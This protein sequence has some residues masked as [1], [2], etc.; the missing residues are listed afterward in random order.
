[1]SE[2]RNRRCKLTLA[3]EQVVADKYAAGVWTA[4]IGREFGISKWS[5]R[6]IAKR[7]GVLIRGRGNRYREFTEAELSDMSS[8]YHAGES[9][10]SIARVYRS[11]QV[12]IS[13]VLRQSG[14][15]PSRRGARRERVS[16]WK[17]GR[18]INHDGYIQVLVDD[19]DPMARM[20]NRMGYIPEHRLIMARKL[21]RVLERSESVH[22]INGNKADN[23]IENLQLR[24]GQHG[25]GKAYQCADCGSYHVIEV[26]LG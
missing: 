5:V 26:S 17:G 14:L 12:T 1:M 16:S 15:I 24:H 25:N 13:R 7:A 2:K 9:Q 22:H 8:R 21:G 18:L 23:R 11:T 3:Q 4:Q 19:D 10:E 20:R 6:D